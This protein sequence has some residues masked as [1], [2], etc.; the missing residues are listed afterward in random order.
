MGQDEERVD[1]RKA[2]LDVGSDCLGVT[3]CAQLE[4]RVD[5]TDDGGH[6]TR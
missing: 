6:H 3:V 4:R 2:D 1:Y 5:D